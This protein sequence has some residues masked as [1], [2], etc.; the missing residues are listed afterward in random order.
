MKRNEPE[1]FFPAGRSLRGNTEGWP[2]PKAQRVILGRAAPTNM[3][4][5]LVRASGEWFLRIAEA[6]HRQSERDHFLPRDL[7]Q[8]SHIR[9]PDE[10]ISKRA[11]LALDGIE[12]LSLLDQE[13]LLDDLALRQPRLISG[14]ALSL[15][16]LHQ[17]LLPELLY[18]L[19]AV[20]L[21]TPAISADARHM[22]EAAEERI[23]TLAHDFHRP[24]PALAE[25]AREALARHIWRG[26]DAEL[27][28]TLARTLLALPEDAAIQA[29]DLVWSAGGAPGTEET[30]NERIAPAAT[31]PGL[32]PSAA[33]R[34]TVRDDANAPLP[35]ASTQPQTASLPNGILPSAAL[36]NAELP[37]AELASAELPNTEPHHTA[38]PAAP[39]GNREASSHGAPNAAGHEKAQPNS[40]A[41]DSVAESPAST[42][43]G[44]VPPNGKLGRG[45][46]TVESIAVEL[47][48]HL[49]NPLVTLKTFVTNA[50]RLGEDPEKLARFSTLAEESIGRMDATLD[51]LMDFARLQAEEPRS[52]DVLGC[53]RAALRDVWAGLDAK[54]VQLEGPT[55]EGFR[56]ALP[57]THLTFA[58][59]T[60]ARYLE[61][62][63]E[64]RG[65]LT[66]EQA[67][68]SSLEVRFPEAQSQRHLREAL[69]NSDES[70]P[71][72]LLLV[73]GAL[74]QGG[75]TFAVE[76]TES[77]LRLLL[78]FP[79]P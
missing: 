31:E 49:K 53:F 55:D 38:A 11:T 54:K 62:A 26:E 16:Q 47:A 27:D 10:A 50:G 73:R 48:H 45:Q 28:G 15:D 41:P 29:A 14:S 72:S 35:E 13:S 68:E 67:S 18:L 52:I 65:T 78:G 44:A 46:S 5:L 59:R 20:D 60:L 12:H 19:A 24:V 30:S 6:V 3:P 76:R 33:P 66:I 74:V 75:A 40:A 7:Q 21:D 4:I 70:F 69:L 9:C 37:T 77:E 42:S 63:V 64:P 32:P 23:A 17:R 57:P 79:Q 34:A 51:E 25:S 8:S 71:L 22:L 39:A 43:G 1:I 36:P 56:S 61:E 2:L 58:F